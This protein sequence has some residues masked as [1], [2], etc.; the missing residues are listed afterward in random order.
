[1]MLRGNPD[2]ICAD[3]LNVSYSAI[4]RRIEGLFHKFG[5]RTKME[6]GVEY[7][8]LTHTG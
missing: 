7:L 4:R 6:L 2:K 8:R 5:V 1:M 3:K